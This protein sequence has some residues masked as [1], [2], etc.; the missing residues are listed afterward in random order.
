MKFNQKSSSI[1][2][3]DAEIEISTALVFDLLQ[4]HP[5]LIHHPG[6]ILVEDGKIVGVIDWGDI[7]SES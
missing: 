6:N 3:P 4:Q 5:D 7:T 1:E 2:T